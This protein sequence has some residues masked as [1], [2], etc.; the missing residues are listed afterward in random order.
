M[1]SP[2]K[3]AEANCEEQ[4]Q[5]GDGGTTAGLRKLDVHCNSRAKVNVAVQLSGTSHAIYI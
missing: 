5:A 2:Q 1:A 4:R 3:Y